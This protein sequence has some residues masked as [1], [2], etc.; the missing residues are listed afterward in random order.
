MQDITYV[1]KHKFPSKFISFILILLFPVS[2]LNAASSF[3]HSEVFNSTNY[4]LPHLPFV[5]VHIISLRA[6]KSKYL[7]LYLLLLVITKKVEL[8]WNTSRISVELSKSAVSATSYSSFKSTQKQ[9]GY[10]N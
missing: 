4:S 5:A 1:R 8:E 9:T 3:R 6:S 10:M 7:F 2:G